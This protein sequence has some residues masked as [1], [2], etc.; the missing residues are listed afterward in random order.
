MNIF[1]LFPLSIGGTSMSESMIPNL[2]SRIFLIRG[3]KVM[4]DEDLARV[5]GVTTKR[6][7]QQVRRNIERFP[8]D[9]MFLLSA[10]ESASLGLHFATLDNTGRGRYR[11]YL[12]FAFT[13]HGA[14]MV[15][16]VTDQEIVGKTDWSSRKLLQG[17]PIY[18]RSK[19]RR[20]KSLSGKPEDAEDVY[21]AVLQPLSD[22]TKA[23]RPEP[24]YPEVKAPTHWYHV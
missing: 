18:Q 14:V 6:L 24:E 21:A 15:R 11:K 16:H 3:H 8:S 23:E 20:D 1:V 12:P 2:A 22:T 9:F 17:D 5:Y 7:N 10:E 13:E 19:D 4:L